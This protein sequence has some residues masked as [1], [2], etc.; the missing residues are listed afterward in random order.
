MS[1]WEGVDNNEVFLMG[2]VV[3]FNGK[4]I[5]LIGEAVS[6]NGKEVS[7]IGEKVFLNGK[8][9]KPSGISLTGENWFAI[10][11]SGGGTGILDTGEKSFTVD[12]NE[13]LDDASLFGD[14]GKTSGLEP[15]RSNGEV[16]VDEGVDFLIGEEIVLNEVSFIAVFATVCEG[17]GDLIID[18]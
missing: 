16:V 3:F 11:G 14:N 18:G 8:A 17:V 10:G 15:K 7:L 6:F 12:G 2:E 9:W 1:S 5:F 13:V 4:E